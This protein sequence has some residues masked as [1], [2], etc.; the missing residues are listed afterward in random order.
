MGNGKI[1]QAGSFVNNNNSI[2]IIEPIYSVTDKLSLTAWIKLE[3]DGSDS[4]PRII[5][6]DGSWG[7]YISSLQKL[8]FF[9]SGIDTAFSSS[10]I[11]LNDNI[12]HHVAVT[13]SGNGINAYIDGVYIGTLAKTGNLLAPIGSTKLT[14]GGRAG[15]DRSWQG[16]LND[17]RIYDHTLTKRNN[18]LAK[19]KVLHYTFNKDEGCSI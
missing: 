14:I 2:V 7:L 19:A 5:S 15:G 9:G 18:D 17:V 13:Y 16:Q 10:S 1:G 11:S 4:F 8:A 6:Q 3:V 12:W